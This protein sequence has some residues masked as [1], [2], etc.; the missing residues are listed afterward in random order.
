MLMADFVTAARYDLPIT[1]IVLDNGKL[2]FIALEQEGK[3]LPEHSIDLVNPDFCAFAEACGG[4][5]IRVEDPGDLGN[6][7]KSAF[8]NGKA[9]VVSVAV[10][11]D[12]LIM[13]P[14]ITIDQA[15][16]FGLAKVREALS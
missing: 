12:E 9:T 6:A 3:G 11:P 7:L 10:S 1:V 4:V 15:Y 16:H 14:K 8:F 5:G 13:P 2:G